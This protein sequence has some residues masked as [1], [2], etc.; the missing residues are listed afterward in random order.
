MEG[1]DIGTVVLPGADIKFFLDAPGGVR[2]GR[3]HAERPGAELAG[4]DRELSERDRRD[5]S[6]ENAPLAMAEDAIYVDTGSLDIE[7]VL[8]VL[9]GH[10]RRKGLIDE[11]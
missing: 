4:V 5:S 2:A 1:R 10:M 6:R 9:I 3:R 8:A 11:A 7:G